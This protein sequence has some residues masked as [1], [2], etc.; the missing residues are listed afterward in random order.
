MV[1]TFDC[2]KTDLKYGSKGEQVTTLQKYL[3]QFGYYM[4]TVDG[5]YG[6]LTVNA[7]KAY[8]KKAGLSQDGW[9]G[10]KTCA[11][12]NKKL[13]EAAAAN[14]KA[15]AATDTFDCTSID[16]RNGSKGDQVKKLQEVLKT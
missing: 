13:Q 6:N 10:P 12:F 16:L 8:Q 15:K 1:D 5:D 9:F 3:K 2:T 7:V 4:A 14:D 11:A